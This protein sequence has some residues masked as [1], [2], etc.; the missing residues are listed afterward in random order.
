MGET[1]EDARYRKTLAAKPPCEKPK[2]RVSP[3]C[4]FDESNPVHMQLRAE[5]W[6]KHT[7]RTGKPFWAVRGEGRLSTWAEPGLGELAVRTAEIRRADAL[8]DRAQ[9][10]GILS[11]AEKDRTWKQVSKGRQSLGDCIEALEGMIRDAKDVERAAV[12]GLRFREAAEQSAGPV[13]PQ[14]PSDPLRAP[15]LRSPRSPRHP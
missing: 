13:I 1:S 10:L 8:M 12:E 14:R 2:R 4:E 9:A 15:S 3:N 7:G 6:S 11:D 5:G